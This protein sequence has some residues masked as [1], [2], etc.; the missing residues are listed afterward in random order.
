MRNVAIVIFSILALSGCGSD[1]G[2]AIVSGTVSYRG[3]PVER[4]LI[5]FIPILETKGPASG[6]VIENGTY[7]ARARG[8]IPLG[9][10]RVEI[11]GMRPT[12]GPRPKGLQGL[13]SIPEPM[14]QYLPKKYNTNS[15]FTL[16]IESSGPMTRN[17]D[18]E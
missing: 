12:G 16:T 13:D 9:T 6:A 15:E 17:F 8:G 7:E 18:L 11:Q 5:R 10:Y 4:G 3:E 2:L 14:E 1:S